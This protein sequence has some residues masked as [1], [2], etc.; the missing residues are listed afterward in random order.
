MST[1]DK[2]GGWVCGEQAH[3]KSR[4]SF[5]INNFSTIPNDCLRFA[6]CN[7]F[8]VAMGILLDD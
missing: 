8:A 6:G 4:V 2:Q 1:F 5:L 3:R 7:V